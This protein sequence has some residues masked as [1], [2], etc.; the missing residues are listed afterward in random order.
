MYVIEVVI[1]LIENIYVC[2]F[3]FFII[4]DIVCCGF[5]YLLLTGGN[6]F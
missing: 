6:S 5:V 3:Y 2:V 4:K 1:N